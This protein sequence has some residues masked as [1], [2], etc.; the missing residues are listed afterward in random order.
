MAET[1]G[2]PFEILPNTH[3]FQ[4]YPHPQFHRLMTFAVE[5]LTPSNK[6]NKNKNTDYK[7]KY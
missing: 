7:Y 3:V 1:Y 5:A 2:C 6:K 4:Q